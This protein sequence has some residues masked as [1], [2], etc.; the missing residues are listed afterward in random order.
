MK[1]KF[2]FKKEKNF[3]RHAA[4]H[5]ILN[6][7]FLLKK[8][9][10]QN[11]PKGQYQLPFS[12]YLPDYIPSTFHYKWE[13]FSK[14][15]YARIVYT[16]KVFIYS[17]SLDLKIKSKKF[18]CIN[19]NKDLYFSSNKPVESYKQIKTCC[20]YDQG[21][22]KLI[23]SF[24]K[25]S[26]FPYENAKCILEIENHSETGLSHVEGEL[27][28]QISIRTGSRVFERTDILNGFSFQTE[29]R[30]MEHRTLQK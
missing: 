21:N 3:K 15:S 2:A 9:D 22:V 5:E 12:F 7:E 17:K 13:D 4:T 28:Q 18:F 1:P 25:E 16:L 6:Y 29:I 26:Y 14:D 19:I 30:P 20:I 27:K 8:F 23:G 24:D 11:T 10:T